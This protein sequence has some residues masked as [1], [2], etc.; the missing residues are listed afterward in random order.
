MFDLN[1]AVR[2]GDERDTVLGV[3]PKLV[4]EPGSVEEAA[5]VMAR[6]AR[7]GARLLFVG[8]GTDLEAGH[9]PEA[10]DAVLRTGGLGRILEHAPSDQIV[11]AEAGVPLARLQETV[12]AHG[13]RLA[14][15][16]PW[17]DRSTLGGLVASNAFGPLR[18]RYGSIRDLII[19]VSIV[20]ADGTGSR[21]GGKVVKTVAGF[22][23]PKLMVGSLG[24]LGLIATVTFRLHPLPETSAMVLVPRCSAALL[25]N[26][27]RE[28][29]RA[30]LEPASA[31]AILAGPLTFDLSVQFEGFAAG[32]EQQRDRFMSLLAQSGAANGRTADRPAADDFRARHDAVRG[33]SSLR[34]KI[35]APRSAVESVA[36]DVL[37]PTL[38]T[39]QDAGAIWYPTLGLGFF[40]GACGAADPTAA[41]LSRAR[42]VLAGFGGSLT[43]AAA[44]AE[45]RARVDVWGDRPS[46]FPLMQAMK[47]RLDPDGRLAPGRF[48]GT[49]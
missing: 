22:D 5:E 7:D 42:S 1:L 12:Q 13:Q 36:A 45:I 3:R 18:A 47:S 48:V 30:Q 26:L 39:L 37:A 29:R 49:L 15:D 35:A 20:R 31:V 40:G 6:C 14:L 2:E 24:T 8:G 46:S 9:P 27:V 21:G 44:P 25:R 33:P 17:P 19:G 32:V 16:P 41:A 34:A 11:V 10:I 23:I 4:F 43:L 28:M 38:A